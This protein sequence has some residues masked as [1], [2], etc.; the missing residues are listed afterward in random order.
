MKKI[1]IQQAEGEIIGKTCS[2]CLSIIISGEEVCQCPHCALPF[3]AECWK[4]NKGCSAYGCQSASEEKKDNSHIPLHT[5]SN[6]WDKSKKCPSCR[7][8]IKA[9]ALKCRYCGT[10]FSNRDAISKTEFNKREY[11]GKEY[12]KI[13][14][15]IILLF[16]LSATGILS[17]VMLIVFA[18]FVFSKRLGK[19]KFI[20][21]PMALKTIVYVA[22]G[23]NIFLTFL[24]ILV[25]AL[26]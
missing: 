11:E 1:V 7:K 6:V 5:T 16:F 15:I 10:S 17:P 20:R 8:E 13:R 21:L 2:I 19:I 3:H 22:F 26:D 25:V 23:L 4:E 14:N 9:Q 18:I 12:L 24:M